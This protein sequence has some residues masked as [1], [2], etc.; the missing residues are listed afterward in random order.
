MKTKKSFRKQKKL[1]ISFKQKGDEGGR[2]GKGEKR[3]EREP[4]K[5]W[6]I[7]FSKGEIERE[8]ERE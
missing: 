8:R 1:K 5:V 7:F 6:K 3:E 4:W 2:K